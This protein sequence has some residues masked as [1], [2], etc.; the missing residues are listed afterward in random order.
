MTDCTKKDDL[1]EVRI[2][3]FMPLFKHRMTFLR[4]IKNHNWKCF[5][6]LA[7]KGSETF[8]SARGNDSIF[9]HQSDLSM[10]SIASF[11]HFKFRI[12]HFT[13]KISPPRGHRPSARKWLLSNFPPKIIN[14]QHSVLLGMQVQY[15]RFSHQSDLLRLSIAPF[16]H[17]KF[18]ILHFTL[19]ISLPRGHRPSARREQ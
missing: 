15:S 1:E 3:C 2:P 14:I 12:L 6:S 5:L 17:F 7:P 9:S 4:S 16:L 18:R 8:G 10:L 13:L 19:R 11:L